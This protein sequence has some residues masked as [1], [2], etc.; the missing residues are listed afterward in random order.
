MAARPSVPRRCIETLRQA[1]GRRSTIR[2]GDA[3]LEH[4]RGEYRASRCAATRIDTLALRRADRLQ[5]RHGPAAAGAGLAPLAGTYSLGGSQIALKSQAAPSAR[6]SCSMGSGPL[7]YLVAR[8][9]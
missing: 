2:P 6:A 5:R 9:T 4:R 8:N 1:E 3:G 7:L